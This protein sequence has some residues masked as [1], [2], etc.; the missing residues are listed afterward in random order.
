MSKWEAW[1]QQIDAKIRA[2][3]RAKDLK[4]PGKF[5]I[6][7]QIYSCGIQVSDISG[8]SFVNIVLVLLC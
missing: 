1:E 3:G 5:M 4:S 7:K 2:K 8:V 6:A